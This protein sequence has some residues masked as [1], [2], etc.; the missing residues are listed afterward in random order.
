MQL[1]QWYTEQASDLSNLS[2]LLHRTTQRDGSAIGCNRK[3][4]HPAA[5]MNMNERR[6][7]L[8]PIYERA[9]RETHKF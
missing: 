9:V 5:Q 2:V 6:P 4:G 1:Q 8:Y 3:N 7:P